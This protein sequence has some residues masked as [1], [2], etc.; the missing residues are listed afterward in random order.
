M[1]GANHSKFINNFKSIEL[2]MS[3]YRTNELY[4]SLLC[5][6]ALEEDYGYGIPRNFETVKTIAKFIGNK[7]TL[8]IAS[9]KCFPEHILKELGV[10][11]VC[12][13][14]NPPS[15]QYME[16]ENLSS[17]EAMF[18]YFDRKVLFICWP[19]VGKS[20]TA[21]I[22]DVMEPEYIIYIGEWEGGC[23]GTDELFDLFEK[24]YT[25]MDLDDIQEE[26]DE[27]L[28]LWFEQKKQE[29]DTSFGTIRLH[30]IH[31]NIFLLKKDS[32]EDY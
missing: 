20:H 26:C 19:D 23:C 15:K 18:W 2:T 6:S 32:E 31:D 1:G 4:E 25:S 7:K 24:K 10:D 22:V 14:I 29:K 16:V 9:G 28:E 8:S 11:I 13:D 27:Y 17:H 3:M 21:D 5:K 12:T 30:G